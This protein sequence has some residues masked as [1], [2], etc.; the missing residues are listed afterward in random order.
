MSRR[1]TVLALGLALILILLPATLAGADYR[2]TDMWENLAPYSGGGLADQHPLSYYALDYHIDGPSLTGPGDTPEKIAQFFMSYWWALLAFLMRLMI[3]AFDWAFNIDIING[4]HGALGTVGS[5]TQHLWYSTFAPLLTTG[6]LCFGV[7]FLFKIAGRRFGEAGSGTIRVVCLTAITL[8]IIF[9]ISGTL[10]R[11]MAISN[12]LSGAIVSGSTGVHGGQSISDRLFETF[13]YKP[14]AV[15]EFGGLKRCVTAIKDSDGYPIPVGPSDP[16]RVICRD[17]LRKDSNGYGGY[18]QRFLSQAPGSDARGLQYESLRDGKPPGGPASDKFLAGFKTD[19]ADAPSVDLMQ[20]EGTLQR[21]LY[22][23]LV[24]FGTLGSAVFLGLICFAALFAQLGLLVLAS[25]TPMVAILSIFPGFH[26][27]FFKWAKLVGK[28]LVAKVIYSVILAAA[29]GVSAALLSVGGAKGYP[30]VLFLQAA[31][32]V[33]LVVC[34]KMLIAPAMSRRDYNHSESSFKSFVG[35]ATTGAVAAVGAPI[36]AASAAGAAGKAR[37]NT[38]QQQHAKNPNTQK[39][40]TGDPVNSNSTQPDSTSPPASA[41]R[42]YSP[43]PAE[44]GSLPAP[45]SPSTAVASIPRDEKTPETQARGEEPV[46]SKS[47][48]EDYEKA[49]VEHGKQPDPAPAPKP[50]VNGVSPVTSFQE[51]LEQERAKTPNT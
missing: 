7:W 23:L 39:V 12:D 48:Q 28:F 20:A 41:G 21:G 26:G 32:F 18:A 47:F 2:G 5:A 22:L 33:G 31:L 29:L 25:A 10:G 16:H 8:A 35:G 36:A 30:F 38:I 43:A 6:V 40:P 45:A 24:T 37:I 34:R 50:P 42:E 11:A 17:A 27:V 46:P 9:N 4:H 14:W 49:R 15:L 51:A 44:N 1:S 19:K 3:A 13:I